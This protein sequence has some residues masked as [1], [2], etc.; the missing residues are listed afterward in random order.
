MLNNKMTD[1]KEEEISFDFF[2]DSISG[3]LINII[4]KLK[5]SFNLRKK[6]FTK[7]VDERR[8]KPPPL[9]LVIIINQNNDDF[10]YVEHH[11]LFMPDYHTY[12]AENNSKLF[13]RDFYG[14]IKDSI[15]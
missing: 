14:L 11:T 7:I 10:S 8:Q 4:N 9:L 1:G 2:E 13:A 15:P 12:K 6:V 5:E 3:E